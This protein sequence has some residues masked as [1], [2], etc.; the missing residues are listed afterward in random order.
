M[1]TTIVLD[2]YDSDTERTLLDRLSAQSLSKFVFIDKIL[3][4]RT[5]AEITKSLKDID[6]IKEYKRVRVVMVDLYNEVL[7]VPTTGAEKF[8]DFYTKYKRII[9]QCGVFVDLLFVWCYKFLSEM[10]ANPLTRAFSEIQLEQEIDTI[11]VQL[12]MDVKERVSEFQMYDNLE[13]QT[14]N[15]Y[16]TALIQKIK[17]HTGLVERMIDA[18]TTQK[19]IEG[20][21]HTEFTPEKKRVVS[22][23]DLGN[24]SLYDVFNSIELSTATPFASF[25]KF[26]KIL[27]TSRIKQEWVSTSKDKVVVKLVSDPKRV[28][29]VIDIY[30]YIEDDKLHV[31][32]EFEIGSGLALADIKGLIPKITPSLKYNFTKTQFLDVTGVFFIPDQHIDSYILSHLVLINPSFSNFFIDES[33]KTTRTKSSIYTYFNYA[34]EMV[35]FIITPKERLKYDKNLPPSIR[36]GSQYIRVKISNAKTDKSIHALMSAFS[37]IVALYNRFRA[38][39]AE[40]YAKYITE[41]EKT[42]KGGAAAAD[43]SAVK[44]LS[45]KIDNKLIPPGSDYRRHCN[46][47]HPLVLSDEDAENYTGDSEI[48]KFPKQSDKSPFEKRNYTCDY[49]EAPY[50]GLIQLGDHYVPCCYKEPNNRLYNEYY[51]IEAPKTRQQHIIITGKNLKYKVVGSLEPFPD[52]ENITYMGNGTVVRRRGVDNSRLSFLQ[53]I[54]E[55]IAEDPTIKFRGYSK[56]TTSEARI[57]GLADKLEEIAENDDLLQVARQAL[58]DKSIDD[59]RAMLTPDVFLNP[60]FFKE[61]FEVM[62][63]CHIVVFN[64]YGIEP[65]RTAKTTIP[66]IIDPSRPVIM[67]LVLDSDT[68]TFPQCE[69]LF[70]HKGDE[71]E[72]RYLFSAS[73]DKCVKYILETQQRIIQSFIGTTPNVPLALDER[74]FKHQRINSFGKTA[75][76]ITTNGYLVYLDTPRPPSNLS[77]AGGFRVSGCEQTIADIKSVIPCRSVK[78]TKAKDTLEFTTT[79]G[80]VFFVPLEPGCKMSDSLQMSQSTVSIPWVGNSILSLFAYNQK[81]ARYLRE[82]MYK[83]F[84]VYL[85]T[86]DIRVINDDTIKDFVKEKIEIDQSVGYKIFVSRLFSDNE[87]VFMSTTGKL[88][89]QSLEILKRLVFCLRVEITQ[90]QQEIFEY[91]NRTRIENFIVDASDFDQHPQ[92][93]LLEGDEAFSQY[94]RE[95]S[96]VHTVRSAILVDSDSTYFFSNVLVDDGVIYMAKNADSFEDAASIVTNFTESG[97]IST[98]P[99]QDDRVYVDLFQYVSEVN[100]TKVSD[101][102][103]TNKHKIISYNNEGTIRYTVL[104]KL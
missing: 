11:S 42:K 46:K 25:D 63:N 78:R 14:I 8:V 67:I 69:L 1:F 84:S 65:C 71:K 6:R 80:V 5:S 21:P 93:I 87:K 77:V 26:Y 83:T 85:F 16:H 70:S 22:L 52:I 13:L 40:K 101:P 41:K 89:V 49:K 62:F 68:R 55:A 103:V 74:A 90:R 30:F 12:D 79:S 18:H 59:I 2:I 92:Q 39:I 57:D 32:Y 53:C 66:R 75:A 47:Y 7:S 102:D 36:E 64:P 24:I 43:K 94:L 88:R 50:M 3:N 96:T 95:P 38:G 99:V 27:K 10:D 28:S 48:V 29:S 86:S 31:S 37:K 100:I 4:D 44:R 33:G 58:Y 35:S 97:V 72:A 61:L 51:N 82:F 15:A 19:E 54:L 98:T 56:G 45:T 91:R 76:Y 17:E 81:V 34:G 9:E 73:S 20:V 104:L 23:T 60:V